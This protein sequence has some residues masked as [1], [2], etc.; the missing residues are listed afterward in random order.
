MTQKC[1]ERSEEPYITYC[2]AC[3][4]RFAR[5]GHSSKHILELIYGAAA[6]D[7]PDISEKRYNRLHLRNTLLKEIWNQEVTPVELGFEIIYTD[8][9]RAMMDE[10]MI[11]DTDVIRVLQNLCETNEAIFD[12]E[13]GLSIARARLGNV[14]FWVKYKEFDGGYEVVSAYSHRMNIVNKL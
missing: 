11:L 9:A 2:M 8:E 10:R 4:D 12:E 5:E 7:C 3:R 1:L 13:S 14:T 6:S